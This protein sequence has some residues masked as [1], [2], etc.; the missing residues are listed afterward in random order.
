M[1]A[2]RQHPAVIQVVVDG[3]LK[4]TTTANSI[5][6]TAAAAAG[7]HDLTQCGGREPEAAVL[8]V[9]YGHACPVQAALQ[10]RAAV[11]GRHQLEAGRRRGHSG[12][13]VLFN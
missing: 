13:S 12:R 1:D 6:S 11:W 3:R 4:E 10:V 2:G 9:L 8:V 7:G 5:D